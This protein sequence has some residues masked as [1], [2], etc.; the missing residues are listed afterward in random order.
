MHVAQDIIYSAPRKIPVRHFSRRQAEEA[1]RLLG[2]CEPGPIGVSIKQSNAAVTE[3]ALA[4]P[5]NVFLIS[6]EPNGR[7]LYPPES[8]FTR[9]LVGGDYSTLVGFDMA[10]LVVRFYRELRLHVQGV[11][12]ST[13]YARSTREP[14][15]PS[16]MIDSKL[17]SAI[18]GTSVDDLWRRGD[19]Q[20][21]T[22]VCL[23]A[24]ISAL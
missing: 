24:W 15:P 17:G 4:T 10:R 16:K 22:A 1:T 7:G 19:G 14:W 6:L 20:D 11:D 8:A 23:R 13:L 21:H 5:T 3:L 12:L 18:G 2:E 9:L